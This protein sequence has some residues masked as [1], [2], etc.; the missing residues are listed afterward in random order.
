[1][2]YQHIF[3]PTSGQKISVE[4]GK[5]EVPDNPVL[6]F[7]QGDG[8][9]PDI[10]RACLR[11]W[12]AAVEQSYGG[13][14]KIHWMELYL[15][16]MAAAR[17][18]GKVFPEETREA[19]KDIV[20][21]I[22][23]PLTTPVG[24]G[25][26]SLNVALRQELDLYACI[27]PVRYYGGVPSPLKNPERVDVVIFRENTED[28]YAGIEYKSGSAENEKL[29]RFLKDE[30]GA[31]FFEGSGLGVK[32]ISEF[33]SK[34]LVRKAIQYAIDN[35][36]E[37]VTLVHKGNIMKYTE[38]AFR[39][40]GYDLAR[41][42]FVEHTIT[43]EELYRIH[44]GKRPEGKV[45]IQ[46][47]IADIMF[48]LM[49]LRPSEFDVIACP[50]LNGDYLS[51]AIAAE[52]G[53]VGIAPGA[54]ISDEVAV[55]E[56][57]HGTAP[58]YANQ[59]KVNPGSLLFSGV[60]M[61]EHIG[62]NI[63]ADLIS[64]AYPEVIKEKIVTYDFARQMKGAHEVSTSGFADALIA[65]IQGSLDLKAFRAQRRDAI[66]QDRTRREQERIAHPYS[67][68]KATGRAPLTIREVMTPNPVRVAPDT[69][70]EEAVE[71]MR[72]NKISSVLVE[73]GAD[74]QWAIMTQKDV[75]SRIVHANRTPHE[76]RTDEVATKPMFTLPGDTSLNECVEQ[77]LKRNIRRI[78][79]A[80]D[81][82]PVGIVSDTDIFRLVEELGFKRLYF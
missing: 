31:K 23:G 74:G 20:I 5:L 27:R 65:Q 51:D 56:A 6:G 37:S 79:V 24:G 12:D 30:L 52:V 80:Q 32:P 78:V 63:A 42:E 7:I 15:G 47:R 72:E 36:R 40:W 54:N 81:D 50:N 43:E 18:D 17:Y 35:K 2:A 28:V 62:W 16:E 76:V 33:G 77:M 39:N 25:F 55:F 46:D 68:M 71:L 38:G 14:R 53:G 59:D 13:K 29:A 4:N 21:S 57:T 8:I 60:M 75:I 44:G 61:L 34:R 67:T 9:G 11:V 58:K 73:P 19:L 26:R 82:Q 70:V 45:V 64:A 10:M 66:E 41:E 48:Q 1:M 3:F 69:S 49:L 22:K